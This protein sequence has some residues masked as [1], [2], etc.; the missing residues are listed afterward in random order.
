MSAA[1]P[2]AAASAPAQLVP[3]S[4]FSIA[5]LTEAY[6]QTRVDYLVPMPMNAARLAEY[7]HSYDVDLEASV[8]AVD[9]D[10]ILGL[11]MLGLR[12]GRSWITRLGVL[13]SA[14]RHG[15]GWAL[16]QGLLAGSDAR[17]LTHNVLEVI[18]NNAPAYNLFVRC[19]FHAQSELLVLRRPPSPPP[20]P[21]SGTVTWLAD[22]AA[23]ALL[24]QRN[25]QPSWITENESLVRAGQVQAV[26]VHRPEGGQGWLVFQVQT[27]RGL[28]MLLTRLTLRTLTGQPAEVGAALL[29]CLY[30]RFP[31]LDTQAENVA[32]T[33]PHLPAFQALGFVEA[34]RRIEMHRTLGGG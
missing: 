19:G 14:R 22:D 6:N 16:M 17:G 29:S 27:F 18:K 3:A 9:G 10:A 12:P 31:D 26:T 34:F 4:R 33:D 23:L 5:Q 11:A 30:T 21:A 2:R 13:P 8:V 7:I 1:V 15:L 32:V 20:A 28:P 25:D 24:A